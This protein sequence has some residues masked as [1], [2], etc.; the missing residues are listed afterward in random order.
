MRRHEREMREPELQQVAL[1]L[2]ER[3][4]F[5]L[6]FVIKIFEKQMSH[7]CP[8]GAAAAAVRYINSAVVNTNTAN[9]IN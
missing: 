6:Y 2:I 9:P 7:E 4:G 3:P 1:T 5:I 8:K